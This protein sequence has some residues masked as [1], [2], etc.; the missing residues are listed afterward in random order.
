[1][2]KESFSSFFFGLSVGAFIMI[3]LIDQNEVVDFKKVQKA[4]DSCKYGVEKVYLDGNYVC[5]EVE[6]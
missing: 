6:K 4:L 5:K 1:M 2:S 3:I